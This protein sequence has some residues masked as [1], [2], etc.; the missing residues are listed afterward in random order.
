MGDLE[1]KVKGILGRSGVLIKNK[2]MPHTLSVPSEEILR[3]TC[4]TCCINFLCYLK[5]FTNQG[6]TKMVA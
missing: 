2:H 6:K 1:M 5:N 4:F 3:E